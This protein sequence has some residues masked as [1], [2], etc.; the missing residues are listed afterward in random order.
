MTTDQKYLLELQ[1]IN[2]TLSSYIEYLEIKIIN[3]EKTLGGRLVDIKQ[4]LDIKTL[5]VG[6]Y[7]V[8]DKVHGQSKYITEGKEYEVI[9]TS[10]DIHNVMAY[11]RDRYFRVIDNKGRSKVL[12]INHNGYNIRKTRNA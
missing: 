7:I 11:R 8:C 2:T 9:Y 4:S 6:D 12:R 3:L 1:R 10:E 5:K